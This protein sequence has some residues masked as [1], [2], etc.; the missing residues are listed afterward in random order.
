MKAFDSF[1][2]I[3]YF[4]GTHIGKQVA[5]ILEREE[6]VATPATC[7]TE[8]KRR[9]KRAKQPWQQHLKFIEA[10]SRIIP[11]TKEMAEKAGDVDALHFADA[12]IYATALELGA[13]VVTG[14]PHFKGLPHVQYIGP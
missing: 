1:A 5:E 10:K 8:I 9:F 12:L 11:L 3:E 6:L 14:D 2:W 7:I 13:T 4:A